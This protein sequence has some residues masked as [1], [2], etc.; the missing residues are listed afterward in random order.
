MLSLKREEIGIR[1]HIYTTAYQEAT[2]FF[3]KIQALEPDLAHL[4]E[5]FRSVE[6]LGDDIDTAEKLIGEINGLAI[7]YVYFLEA[8]SKM[9]LTG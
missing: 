6:G 8:P 1:E 5:I 4:L 2:A 3:K 9:G 7:W